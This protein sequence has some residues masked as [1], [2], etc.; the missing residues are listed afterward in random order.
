MWYFPR[1]YKLTEH[2][3]LLLMPPGNDPAGAVGFRPAADAQ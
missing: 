3:K 1:A 2:G